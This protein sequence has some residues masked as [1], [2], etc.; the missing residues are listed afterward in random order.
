M[1]REQTEYLGY[2]GKKDAKPVLVLNL[3]NPVNPGGGVRRG[4]RAQEE[5]LCRKSSLLLSLESKN[6]ARYYEYNRNL[7]TYLGSDAI[8][9][10]PQVEII[11]DEHGNLLDDTVIVAVMTCAAP[12]VTRGKEGLSESE[13]EDLVYNRITGMLKCAAHFGYK[14]LILGAWGCGA[15]GNDAHVV[16]DLFYKALKE[17]DYGDLHEKDL[18]R[19]IGF[20]VLDRTTEQYNYKEFARN[21]DEDNFYRDENQTEIDMGRKS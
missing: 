15:F 5:D 20:A 6:A 21:F 2:D 19:S 12:M 8:I 18:F 1:A 3:A 13:Y 7:N 14:H 17:L 16:S 4:A 9:F 10:T 11:R